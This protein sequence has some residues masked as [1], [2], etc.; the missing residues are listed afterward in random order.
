VQTAKLAASSA[1]DANEDIAAAL[2][3]ALANTH[4]T[5]ASWYA[6][7][8]G[9]PFECTECGKCCKTQ[10]S[11]YMNPHEIQQAANVLNITKQDFITTY[12]SR[13][14]QSDDADL[15][16][17]IR[18]INN[19]QGACVFL[20][21]DTNHCGIYKA[22]PVQCSTYPFWSNIM[23]S[24]ESWNNEVRLPDDAPANEDIPYWTSHG[25]GCEGM[26][27]IGD[28]SMENL[29]SP[30]EAL[31]QLMEYEGSEQLFPTEV[32]IRRV[33]RKWNT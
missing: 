20:D 19:N 10:G 11:V 3:R 30:Y 21:A 14:L 27:K 18:L 1:D 2:A 31:E 8:G 9:L 4:P 15:D 24:A 26:K 22:R 29:V 16:P 17:W 13:T 23:E 5:Q 7:M 33:K 32:I 25:G 12:A 6:E 28:D